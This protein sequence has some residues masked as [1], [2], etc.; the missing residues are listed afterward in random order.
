[1]AYQAQILSLADAGTG[2]SLSDIDKGVFVSSALGATQISSASIPFTPVITGST[3]SGTVGYLGGQVG[4]YVQ[5]GPLIIYSFFIS[6]TITGSPSG[7][8]QVSLPV[9]PSSIATHAGSGTVTINS[10]SYAAGDWRTSGASTNITYHSYAN[11]TA[12]ISAT[13]Y[14]VQGTICYFI[15]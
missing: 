6:G 14:T 7:N 1:M 2:Q 11:T 15:D 8:L 4:Y 13:A 12:P 5:I 3:A 10:T 9:A